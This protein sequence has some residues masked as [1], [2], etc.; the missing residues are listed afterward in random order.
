[1]LSHLTAATFENDRSKWCATQ[2]EMAYYLGGVSYGEHRRADAQTSCDS[3]GSSDPGDHRTEPLF[4]TGNKSRDAALGV[5]RIRAG[6]IIG[7]RFW[8]LRDGLLF[9]VFV[10]YAWRPDVLERSSSKHCAFKNAGYHAFR[11]EEQ[12]EQAVSIYPCISPAVIGSVAMWGEVIEHKHGWRSEY[13][14]VRS[15]TKIMGDRDFSSR[16]QLLLE[17][18]QK[19]R[20]PAVTEL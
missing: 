11:D 2:E 16:Q 4:I 9:S 20:C 1:M 18:R 10:A 17:L 8:K 7:W 3:A 14:A 19:Y 12:A 15:I 13:A 6:E 5:P